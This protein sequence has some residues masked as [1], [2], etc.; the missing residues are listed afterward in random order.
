ML[1]NKKKKHRHCRR[2]ERFHPKRLAFH[3]CSVTIENPGNGWRWAC[4]ARFLSVS[5]HRS[6]RLFSVRF[7]SYDS[8]QKRP[9]HSS[10]SQTFKKG[11]AELVKESSIWAA[12][13]FVFIGL[14]QGL[15]FFINVRLYNI[16]WRKNAFISFINLQMS[17]LTRAGERVSMQMRID[18]YTKLLQMPI[19][20]YDDER[21]SPGTFCARLAVDVPVVR[22]VSRCVKAHI[23]LGYAVCRVH[24]LLCLILVLS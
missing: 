11:S 17:T 6:W 7:S 12:L 21:N 16:S 20:Y 9:I 22:Y 4:W 15:G 5:A 19:A 13:A 24:Q 2:S 8:F 14:M 10:S 23:N 1:M 18:A 3:E